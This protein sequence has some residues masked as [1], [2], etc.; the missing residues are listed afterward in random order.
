[1]SRKI[2]YVDAPGG[3]MVI[4]RRCNDDHPEGIDGND[5]D[6]VVGVIPH[7]AYIDL[8]HA[9]ILIDELNGN[10]EMSEEYDPLP[11]GPEQPNCPTCNSFMSRLYM[12][13]L[14]NTWMAGWYNCP[15][16]DCKYFLDPE[17][18]RWHVQVPV[19]SFTILRTQ[20]AWQYDNLKL[21]IRTDLN[22]YKSRDAKAVTKDGWRA[23]IDTYRQV[24][25]ICRFEAHI[26][27]KVIDGAT[28]EDIREDEK[29]R[30]AEWEGIK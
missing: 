22:K 3:L 9:K 24:G 11:A 17:T 5:G 13:S 18:E 10:T 12:G 20:P 25:I 4:L 14:K 27:S 8:A 29:A 30:I 23:R 26:L 16:C 19:D 7:A 21:A 1:M 15:T 28:D 2:S 6:I